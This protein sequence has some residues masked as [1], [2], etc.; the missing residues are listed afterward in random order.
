MPKQSGETITTTAY[1]GDRSSSKIPISRAS[2]GK[3]TGVSSKVKIV[4]RLT[5]PFFFPFAQKTMLLDTYV[6]RAAQT[7][8]LCAHFLYADRQ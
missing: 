2:S 3:Q 1:A 5:P 4:G 8:T 6:L 7:L